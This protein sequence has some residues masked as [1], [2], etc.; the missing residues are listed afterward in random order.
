[1]LE[2]TPLQDEEIMQHMVDL[3]KANGGRIALPI[4]DDCVRRFVHT[5]ADDDMKHDY[6]GMWHAYPAPEEN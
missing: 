6:E 3:L 5:F 2:K 4:G 1:M